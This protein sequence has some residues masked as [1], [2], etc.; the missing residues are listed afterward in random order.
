MMK[1]WFN[2]GLMVV[3]TSITNLTCSTLYTVK[4]SLLPLVLYY[5]LEVFHLWFSHKSTQVRA[6]TVTGI[7]A[8]MRDIVVGS[9]SNL[10][11]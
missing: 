3:A 9:K 4:V 8:A 7:C 5:S 6:D 1:S 10:F 2:C 11:I